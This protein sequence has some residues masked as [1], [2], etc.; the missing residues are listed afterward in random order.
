MVLDLSNV[1]AA[2]LPVQSVE[3]VISVWGYVGFGCIIL[4]P[5]VIF[6]FIAFR[7]RIKAFFMKKMNPGRF[8]FAVFRYPNGRKDV[9]PCVLNNE[10]L[11]KFKGGTYIID[12]D[13]FDFY[14]PD[15]LSSDIASQ[16]WFIGDPRPIRFVDGKYEQT[17]DVV[18]V[19]MS[20]KWMKEII[21]GAKER[22]LLLISVAL[23]VVIIIILIVLKYS[24]GVPK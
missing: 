12:N 1:V 16:E 7:N 8:F 17:S 2:K 3:P 10:G 9:V 21:Q 15:L 6:L 4:V 18:D 22:I 23:N 5:V 13:A 20:N 14:K 11:V 19:A 24:E